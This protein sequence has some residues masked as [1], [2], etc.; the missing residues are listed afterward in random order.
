[1]NFIVDAQLPKSLAEF[2]CSKGHNA[3]HTIDLPEQNRTPDQT[4]ID[5]SIKQNR[6]VISKDSDFLESFLV[7]GLPEKLL[8]IKTG[9]IPNVE[10]LK[11]FE[12]HIAFIC[13]G[14]SKNSLME[15]T[16]TEIVIHK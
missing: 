1:M 2:L 14:M 10:L 16:K 13:E 12:L 7:N 3:F 5:I 15:V 4:I 11:I 6:I 9:N 8:L